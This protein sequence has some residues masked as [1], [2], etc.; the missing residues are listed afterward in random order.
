V[1]VSQV[2]AQGFGTACPDFFFGRGVASYIEHQNS[3][4]WLNGS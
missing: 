4:K 1:S 3:S 2:L